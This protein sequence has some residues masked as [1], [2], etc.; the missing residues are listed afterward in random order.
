MWKNDENHHKNHAVV[1]FLQKSLLS[2][3][4]FF[5]DIFTWEDAVFHGLSPGKIK[6]MAIL[7]FSVKKFKLL[8]KNWKNHA[9]F[10]SKNHLIDP[11][12]SL[13]W[14]L[15]KVKKYMNR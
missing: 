6:L 9:F 1:T 15:Y 3:P 2:L 4:S 12:F 5:L 14:Y 7:H 10:S 11:F 13:K 8:E